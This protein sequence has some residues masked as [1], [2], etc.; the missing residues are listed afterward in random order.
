MVER[1]DI[2]SQASQEKIKVYEEIHNLYLQGK[3][4]TVREHN[5][6]FPAMTVDT[7]EIHIITDILSLEQWY[8]MKKQTR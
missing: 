8:Q 7:E 6:G 2:R 1:K 3:A 4:I 5:S